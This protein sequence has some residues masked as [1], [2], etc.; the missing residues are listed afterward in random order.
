MVTE[1]SLSYFRSLVGKI[2]RVHKGGP[3]SKKGKLVAVTSDYLV[4]Q[5]DKDILYY[6]LFHVKMVTK[7]NGKLS[8]KSSKK[9]AKFIQA[10]SFYHVL[11]NL[12]G[13]YVLINRGAH[14]SR[15]GKLLDVNSDHLV[16]YTSDDRIFYF[17]MHHIKVINK[18][19]KDK[20]YKKTIP[21]YIE[22]KNIEDLLQKLKNHYIIINRGTPE[23]LI[24]ILIDCSNGQLTLR[25]DKKD[26]Q[27]RIH[28]IRNIRKS[29]RHIP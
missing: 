16:L 15:T 5:T 14:E 10:E 28:H 2:V 9:T 27:I 26:Y 6:S 25:I 29:D 19:K 13:K 21:P 1:E 18:M 20:S 12:K 17:N 22:E 23:K 4:L 7:N 24:G 11:K 8:L 3:K